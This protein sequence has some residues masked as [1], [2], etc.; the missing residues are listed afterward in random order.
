[1]G[2]VSLKTLKATATQ[3]KSFV[4]EADKNKDGIVS[5]KELKNAG[6]SSGARGPFARSSLSMFAATANGAPTTTVAELNKTIDATVKDLTAKDAN[7]DGF[8]DK[9]AEVTAARKSKRL[10]AL[11]DLAPKSAVE[12]YGGY[13]RNESLLTLLSHVTK[14]TEATYTSAAQ[15]PASVKRWVLE[16]TGTTTFTDALRVAQGN[17]T[18][19]R[20]TDVRTDEPHVLVTW[21]GDAAGSL[22]ATRKKER[23]ATVM[24]SVLQ[25]L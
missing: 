18:V 25:P 19:R 12:S 13:G 16:A 2:T 1:M 9:G 20:F 6:Y 11:Y 10:A 15:V 8:L 23:T 5:A 17:L 14:K 4:T 24:G 22:F 3:L 21:A 7:H